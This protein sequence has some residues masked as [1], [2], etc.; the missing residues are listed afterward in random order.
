MSRE[1]ASLSTRQTR[2]PP[3]SQAIA[4]AA[5]ACFFFASQCF[6]EYSNPRFA[7]YI[8]DTGF[9]FRIEHCE[10]KQRLQ[11]NADGSDLIS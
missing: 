10:V 9:R 8:A 6:F 11:C 5:P 3:C 7:F 2:L 4:H 1:L